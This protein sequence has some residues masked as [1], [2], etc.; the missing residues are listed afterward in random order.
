MW[1]LIVLMRSPFTIN[2]LAL[3][4][5][6]LQQQFLDQKKRSDTQMKVMKELKSSHNHI[7]HDACWCFGVF[8]SFIHSCN[9]VTYCKVKS[10]V[11][12]LIHMPNC[13]SRPS[14]HSSYICM[15]KAGESLRG[16]QPQRH[17]LSAQYLP[18]AAGASSAFGES[19]SESLYR[20]PMGGE[21]SSYSNLVEN[22]STHRGTVTHSWDNKYHR[23]THDPPANRE[24]CMDFLTIHCCHQAE[25]SLKANESLCLA[26]KGL[27]EWLNQCAM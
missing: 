25:S 19:E 12:H 6:N 24:Q 27:F 17:S 7:P 9:L 16:N 26:L 3:K 8:K 22:A 20:S 11:L 2:K 18:G 15:S 10:S 14:L 21:E 23:E 1:N 13:P 5:A 4:Y